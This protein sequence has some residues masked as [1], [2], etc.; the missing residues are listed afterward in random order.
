MLL[1][2]WK[3]FHF[4]SKNSYI[5]R[6][7]QAAY[8]VQTLTI[9]KAAVTRWLSHGVACK[10]ARE[11]YPMIIESLDDIISKDPKAELIGLR[12]HMLNP[13]T[14]LQICFL[15]DVLSITNILSLVLQSNHKDFGAIQRAMHLTSSQLQDMRDN[16]NSSHLKSFNN[17]TEV[18]KRINEFEQQNVIGHSTRKR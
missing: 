1:G 17:C 8:G 10:R 9:V 18:L 16:I 7:I 5:F 6:E 15:E 2:L 4:S 11:R 14:L 3:A 12:D 13:E